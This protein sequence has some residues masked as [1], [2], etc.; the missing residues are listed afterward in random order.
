MFLLPLIYNIVLVLQVLFFSLV[1]LYASWKHRSNHPYSWSSSLA[2]GL[3]SFYIAIHV[4]ASR[5]I[6]YPYIGFMSWWSIACFT[7]AIIHALRVKRK[8]GHEVQPANSRRNGKQVQ[9]GKQE[10]T[11]DGLESHHEWIRKAF[12]LAGFLVIL[13]FYV[14][15]PLIAPLVD[16]A[17]EIAGDSY[18]TLWGPVEYI[19]EFENAREAGIYLTLFA[20]IATVIFVSCVDIPRV[21]FGEQYSLIS[22][23]EARAGKIL[24]EKEIG[25]PGPETFIAIGATSAWIIG[26]AF[27][28]L[29]STSVEM[30][31]AGIMM[32]TVAD[33]MAAIIGKT[34]G[35]HEIKR[36]HGQLKTVEGLIA[37]L[38]TAFVVSVFFAGWFLALFG[39]AI[40]MVIDYLSPPIADN[41]I[42]APLL[43]FL[44]CGMK[45]LL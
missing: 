32:S 12:H 11:L 1:F 6:P 29:E 9:N 15:G 45:A 13:A 33:G 44:L 41:V 21:L 25:V 24:R 5:L 27:Q 40:F 20:L 26:I 14:V 4:F 38:V 8:E 31:I 3:L 35:K 17:I 39:A 28:P 23:I 42:N 10:D 2:T 43:T 34:Y 16:K 36:P 18:K 19:V 22:L 30:A 7:L 37:G